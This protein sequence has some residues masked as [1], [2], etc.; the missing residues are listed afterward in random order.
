[1][2]AYSNSYFKP[3]KHTYSSDLAKSRNFITMTTLPVRVEHLQPQKHPT[4]SIA[5]STEMISPI[6]DQALNHPL[7]QPMASE[8]LSHSLS[9][10]DPDN[11]MNWPLYRKVYVS[12][13]GFLF[14]ASA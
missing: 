5:G 4:L 3:P 10:V 12:S 1:M 13:C 6:G 14:A 11:P 8:I 2:S 9:P 7:Y